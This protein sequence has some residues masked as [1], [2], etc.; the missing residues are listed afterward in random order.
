[1]NNREKRVGIMGSKPFGAWYL[2][3]VERKAK[4]LS[5][6]IDGRKEKQKQM[7]LPRF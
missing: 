1:M 2:R 5:V 6:A 3:D 4:R 7:R